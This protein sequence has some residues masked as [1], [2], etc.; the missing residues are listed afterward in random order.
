MM[1]RTMFTRR[2]FA[3][4]RVAAFSACALLLSGCASVPPA[5]GK[6]SKSH[7]KEIPPPP[8]VMVV[9][10]PGTSPIGNAG[11]DSNGDRQ[12]IVAD[13]FTY[14]LLDTQYVI[15]IPKGFITDLASV[16]R[17]LWPIL[18]PH[19]S[20]MNAAIIHDYLYWDQRCSK[21]EA[22][23]VLRLAMHETPV[24]RLPGWMVYRGVSLFGQP[25]F[26][27]N[28]KKKLAGT[29]RFLEPSY[30][31]RIIKASLENSSVLTG[32]VTGAGPDDAR[33][34][35]IGNPDIQHFCRAAVNLASQ[36]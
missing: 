26:S 16:P 10:Y 12:W 33:V 9:S 1:T 34:D 11:K 31:D 4:S 35:D 25:S 13:S 22:D 30:V 5:G 15:S 14:R 18:A 36:L 17:P 28:K 7:V 27:A 3:R 21:S 2:P 20:Y 24:A 29:R 32:A 23:S 8:V 6:L 19:D